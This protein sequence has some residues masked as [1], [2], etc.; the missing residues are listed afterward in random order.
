MLL[1]L[2]TSAKNGAEIMDSMEG[3]SQGWWRPSPGS[4]YPLLQ[5]MTS[6]G[7]LTKRPDGKYEITETGLN[8]VSWVGGTRR[9]QPR[10]VEE[11]LV[12]LSSYV[13]YLEDLNST[14][15]SR[16]AEQAAKLAELCKRLESLDGAKD[17]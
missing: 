1:S 15:P 4:V 8:E 17:A 2:K 12:E 16:V 9:A 5:T 6:E 13:A 3:S 10:T 7:L 14:D 11:V